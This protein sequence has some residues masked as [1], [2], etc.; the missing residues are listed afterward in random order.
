VLWTGTLVLMGGFGIAMTRR[1]REFRKM[2]AK[3]LE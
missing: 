1:I 3:G 2:K